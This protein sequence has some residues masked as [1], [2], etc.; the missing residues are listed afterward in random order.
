MKR[1]TF[2][3]W[4]SYTLMFIS[5]I[6]VFVL[7]TDQMDWYNFLLVHGVALLVI[8]VNTILLI[9]FGKD[10]LFNERN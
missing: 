10:E 2:K 6:A 5:I 8:I 7:G 9:L 4:V 3:N 1:H